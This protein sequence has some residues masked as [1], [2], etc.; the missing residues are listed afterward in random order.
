MNEQFGTHIFEAGAFVQL[1]P[2]CQEMEEV[3][4]G[5]YKGKLI[6]K[7]AVV[8]GV[9]EVWFKKLEEQPPYYCQFQGIATSLMG[10]MKVTSSFT[11]EGV[12][13]AHTSDLQGRRSTCRRNKQNRRPL[14]GGCSEQ[15]G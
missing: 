6:M 7:L 15:H 2:G 3:S 14:R 9:F 5:E 10:E 1:V 12:K 4:P 8:K 13:R 11:L